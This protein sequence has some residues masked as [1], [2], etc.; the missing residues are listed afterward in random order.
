M[1]RAGVAEVDEVPAEGDPL[2]RGRRRRPRRDPQGE[3]GR[4]GVDAGRGGA[5]WSRTRPARSPA[6]ARR[7]AT[8]TTPASSGSCHRGRATV[9]GGGRRCRSA[10]RDAGEAIAWLDGHVNLETGVGFTAPPTRSGAR[11]RWTGSASSRRCSARHRPS[12][13]RCTSPART[14][15]PR[16]RGC[17]R[18][19]SRRP[20]GRSGSPP[21]RTSS[22]SASGWCGTATRSTTRTSLAVLTQIEVTEEFLTELP[23]YFEIMVAAAFT[24][25][26]DVAV[27][28]GGR[29]G[30]HGRDVGRDQ[31]RGRRRRGGHQ[32]RTRPPA[33]LGTTRAE[34]ADRQGRDHPAPLDARAR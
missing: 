28:V 22:T 31:R 34:I 26:A 11:R 9:L 3:V 20:A 6:R 23:S 12:S 4:Q 2:V 7:A 16:R 18:R 29:G 8:C 13:R 32:R 5:V 30:R 19:C 27:H 17:S 24:F 21:A 25:F 10:D 14:A 33:F 15:R 1:H